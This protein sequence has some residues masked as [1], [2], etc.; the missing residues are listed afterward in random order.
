MT[1][2]ELA[3][4]L[5][6]FVGD[7]PDCGDWEWDDFVSVRA[8]PNLEPYRLRLLEDVHPHLGKEDR[9]A[10]VDDTLREVIAELEIST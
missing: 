9:A 7:E 3:S 2:A 10:E 6:R 1:R 4:M 5:R 8:Q